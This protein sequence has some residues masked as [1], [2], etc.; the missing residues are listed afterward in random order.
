MGADCI[1][2]IPR[3]ARGGLRP[4]RRAPSRQLHAQGVRLIITVDCG[5]TALEEA[6]L[7]RELG[8]D[9]IITDHHECKEQL[10]QA[11]GRCGPAPAGP[12]VSAH[13]TLLRRRRRLQAGRCA[14]SGDQEAVARR[15][16][17]LHLP[18]HDR[19]RHAAAAARTAALSAMGLAGPA[20]A[21]SGWACGPSSRSAAACEQADHCRHRGL[22]A[23][24]AHQRRRAAWSQVELAVRP[25]SDRRTR[26]RPTGWPKRSA[27]L[28]REPADHRGRD[29][30]RG[31]QPARATADAGRAPS[32][33]RAT[34]WHQGVVGIVASRLAEEYCRPTFLIC[35]D[36]EQRQGLLPLL[37]RL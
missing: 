16:C 2:Y 5:I 6:A 22:Y 26:R 3:A 29:L 13:R 25:V 20:A 36:G 19:R 15:Y 34:R 12:D 4:E 23:G 10:P 1:S 14:G 28:N 11:H 8:I 37:R 18:R 30:R 17:D 7:C 35:L 27:S 9:L 31:R 21:R 32:S 24:A 33:W